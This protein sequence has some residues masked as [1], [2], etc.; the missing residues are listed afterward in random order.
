M[1]YIDLHIHSSYSDGELS[2]NEI[3]KLAKERNIH[4]LSITDH[5]SIT[6]YQN[7]DYD[8]LDNINLITGIELSVKCDIGKIHILGYG[9]D[10][11][12]KVLNNKLIELKDY[13]VHSLLLILEQIKKDYNI[14]FPKEDIDKIL[15]LSRAV[16]R[17]DIAKLCIKHGY[18][19]TVK[20]AFTKYLVNA[21]N[22]CRSK[23]KWMDYNE[24]IEL[25]L[26]AKGIPVLAHPRSLLLSD[27]ELYIKLKEMISAGLKGIEVYH[28]SHSDSEIAY[29]LTLAKEFNLLISAGSDY[30]GIN[31][32]PDIELSTKIS[33]LSL[34]KQLKRS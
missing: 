28:S 22:K 4:T 27:K 7:I 34:V 29:Y 9:F 1:K 5:D 6:A 33:D 21:Y 23:K 20:E 11:N 8:K 31:T 25:I 14:V 12:D 32:K 10:V 15:N 18:S 2:P 26:N 24:A 19:T 3:I 13:S 17:V 30:H 16:G